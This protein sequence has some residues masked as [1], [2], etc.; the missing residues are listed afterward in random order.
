M[1]RAEDAYAAQVAVEQA[2]MEAI[3][4]AD[5]YVPP[6]PWTEMRER[7]RAD[8]AAQHVADLFPLK[9]IA[10]V[11]FPPL[12]LLMLLLWA[13]GGLRARRELREEVRTELRSR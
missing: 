7:E 6:D 8:R 10:G 12:G 4:A 13:L 5:T 1:G 9:L 2:R 11:C 3:E